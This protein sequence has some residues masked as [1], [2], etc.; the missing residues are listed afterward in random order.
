MMEPVTDLAEGQFA[1]GD[2]VFGAPYDPV[3]LLESGLDVGGAE[4]R[5]QDVPH[6]SD[7]RMLFGRDLTT[8]PA[9]TF[10]LGVRDDAGDVYRVLDELAEAWGGWTVR[11]VPGEVL[12]LSYCRAGRVRVVYGRPRQLDTETPKRITHDFRVVT[13]RFQLSDVRSYSGVASE[14][15]LTT[16]T[17]STATGV[18]FPVVFPVVF[19]G[20]S[21]ERAG[22]VTVDSPVPTPFTLVITGP[23]T[24]TASGFRLWSTGWEISLP[25]TLRP[26]QTLTVDTATGVVAINGQAVST[27]IGRAS[28]LGARMQSG[29]QEVRFTAVDPSAT[30]TATIRWREASTSW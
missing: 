22:W 26:G 16:V 12:P 21:S 4:W 13:A 29:R 1:L 23:S 8:P 10:S 20:A 14:L 18:V 2:Y 28:N 6:P 27:G 3:F 24:G 30:V 11:G 19:G 25:V 15:T 9:W 5:T 7:D 17:T